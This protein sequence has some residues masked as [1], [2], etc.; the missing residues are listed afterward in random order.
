MRRILRIPLA[1][2]FSLVV[3]GLGLRV[4]P[5][6]RKWLASSSQRALARPPRDANVCASAAAC[7]RAC[8]AGEQ[9]ACVERGLSLEDDPLNRAEAYRLY[10]RACDAKLSL[11]CDQAQRFLNEQ[12][13]GTRY[14]ELPDAQ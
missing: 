10:L 3:I 4:E 12:L 6:V 13:A 14:S 7:E 8:A 5:R 1:V 11:G 2:V 9:R